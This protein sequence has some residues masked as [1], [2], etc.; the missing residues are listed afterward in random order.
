MATVTRKRPKPVEPQRKEKQVSLI[1][2]YEQW[3]EVKCWIGWTLQHRSASGLRKKLSQED[4]N[5]LREAY[6]LI[7]AKLKTNPG[8]EIEITESIWIMF[9]IP[10]TLFRAKWGGGK[11][12]HFSSRSYGEI[13]NVL[14]G[15]RKDSF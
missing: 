11:L 13:C 9:Q 8:P 7:D 6:E 4:K 5:N 15:V 14:N 10:N 12:A 2:Q 1:L 3:Q